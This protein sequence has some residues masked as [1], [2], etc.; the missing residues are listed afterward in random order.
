MTTEEIRSAVLKALAGVA[1]EADLEHL[2]P[3]EDLRDA[4]DIDS[5]DV[6]RFVLALHQALGVE[7]AE[8][9]YPKL[10]TLAGAVREL[11]ERLRR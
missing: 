10:L 5:M 4:L 8:K 11:G 7:I 1:P 3:N 6:N 2:G 9:D